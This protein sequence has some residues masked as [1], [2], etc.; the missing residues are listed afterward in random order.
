MFWLDV[1][2]F[3]VGFIINIKGWPIN[4][5]ASTARKKTSRPKS[6]PLSI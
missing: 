5:S 2:I 1:G 3:G 6:I 4:R